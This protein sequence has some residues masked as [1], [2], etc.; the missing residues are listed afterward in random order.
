[1]TPEQQK[2]FYATY[3]EKYG[4]L[5]TRGD[6]IKI[7]EAVLSV[8]P[9]IEFEWKPWD[10]DH[11]S[12]CCVNGHHIGFIAKDVKG[13]Y[14]RSFY[15]RFSDIPAKTELEARHAVQEAFKTWLSG[16]GKRMEG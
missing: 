3:P 16:I 2:V 9:E 10:E 8:Q 7:V 13:F 5:L 12:D 15:G 6:A 11:S 14:Y 1:M 4:N